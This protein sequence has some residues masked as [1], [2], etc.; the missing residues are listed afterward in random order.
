[1]APA[2]MQH[3]DQITERIR[4]QVQVRNAWFVPFHPD[5]GNTI[6]SKFLG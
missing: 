6:V 2:A 5:L 4:F 3:A 1:M